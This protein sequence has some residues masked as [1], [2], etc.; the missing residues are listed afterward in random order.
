M[1][2]IAE[3]VT[4]TLGALGNWVIVYAAMVTDRG[5]DFRGLE[6]MIFSLLHLCVMLVALPFLIFAIFKAESINTWFRYTLY[7]ESIINTISMII[8][9][10]ELG[11]FSFHNLSGFDYLSIF[12]IISEPLPIYLLYVHKEYSIKNQF[13]A[14]YS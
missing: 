11:E 3:I 2:R 12:A 7:V 6:S 8:Y 4:V 10:Y 5:G 14:S 13:Y 9:Y 1:V